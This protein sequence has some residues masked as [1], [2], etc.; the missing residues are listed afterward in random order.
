M[1][2]V[3]EEDNADVCSE[4]GDEV[5]WETHQA[6]AGRGPVRKLSE[7]VHAAFTPDS[8]VARKIFSRVFY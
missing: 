2:S 7:G 6:Q 4:I 8:G 1:V 5:L 3:Q